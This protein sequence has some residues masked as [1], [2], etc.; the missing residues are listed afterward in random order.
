MSKFLKSGRKLA[1]NTTAITQMIPPLV[2][3]I[4]KVVTAAIDA[5]R[6]WP[7]SGPNEYDSNSIPASRPRQ[8]VRDCLVPHRRSKQGTDHVGSPGQSQK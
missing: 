2:T 8:I 4:L 5:A 1:S 7:A 6:I 3:E